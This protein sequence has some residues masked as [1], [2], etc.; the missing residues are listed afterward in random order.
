[1]SKIS[2]TITMAIGDEITED[3]QYCAFIRTPVVKQC[4]FVLVR[5]H[6]SEIACANIS[7]SIAANIFPQASL[8]IYSTTETDTKGEED[9]KIN[10][11]YG[12]DL[13]CI[14][15]KTDDPVTFNK[16][17]NYA[18]L[19]L[20][21]PILYQMEFTNT[22]NRILNNVTAL[23][24]LQD[25]EAHL[26]ETYGDIFQF[27]KIGI[28]TNLNDHVYEQVLVQATNDLNVPNYINHTYKINHNYC[29][30]F[31]D[32][33]YVSDDSDGEIT[34]QFINYYDQEKFKKVNVEDFVDMHRFTNLSGNKVFN[35]RNQTLNKISPSLTSIHNDMIF[36]EKKRFSSTI[37]KKSKGK[38][39]EVT[40]IED[41]VIKLI[42]G[43]ELVKSESGYSTNS[44]RLYV[45]DNY[46]NAFQRLNLTTSLLVDKIS[47]LCFMEVDNGLPDYPQFGRIYNLD[48][49]SSANY[50]F[51]PLNICNIFIR[52]T[53]KEA[54]LGHSVKCLMVKYGEI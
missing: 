7:N 12:H 31:F 15:M 35:D 54:F 41:R 19:V 21:H 11:V 50:S 40:L 13:I 4:S 37:Q 30:Y 16:Q 5:A 24:V 25:F 43:G 44:S 23:E 22:Y 45:P 48:P 28:T 29:P 46:T 8:R 34:G 26:V 17:F 9:K 1:M 2:Y 32:E 49:E 39:S 42:T 53:G 47:Q 3:L 51:T 52:K 27:N 38:Q 14:N 18:E 10:L 36:D 33:F 6:L 20:V